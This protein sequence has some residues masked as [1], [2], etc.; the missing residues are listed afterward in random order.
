M[1]KRLGIPTLSLAMLLPLGGAGCT[2]TYDGTIV[3]TY[4]LVMAPESGAAW[5][6]LDKADPLPRNRLY[7]FPPAPPPPE[8]VA[9]ASPAPRRI[10]SPRISPL[11]PK[12]AADAPRPVTCRNESRDGRIRLVCD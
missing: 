7:R 12:I 9:A 5:M 2:R 8:P 4:S 6:T 10:V 3:P 11:L 1:P